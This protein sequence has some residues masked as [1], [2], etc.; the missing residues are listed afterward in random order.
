[1]TEQQAER[2]RRGQS[3][4]AKEAA[5]QVFRLFM[6]GVLSL[7]AYALTPVGQRAKQVWE[8]PGTLVR[9]DQRLEGIDEA[10]AERALHV[11]EK[12]D[13]MQRSIS[14]LQRPTEVF[15]I[16]VLNSGPIRGH[17]VELAPCDVRLKIS[18]REETVACR[19]VPG[20]TQW[21]F[22]NPR[23]DT[24]STVRRMDAATDRNIGTAW[25]LI[26]IRIFT[27][28]GLEPEALFYFTAQ[29]VACP[30][31][32]EGTEPITDKSESIP[33]RILRPAPE[34]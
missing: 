23:T 13:V 2:I 19:I 18:R 26:D 14:Q 3:W 29:Y 16:S 21:A 22:L 33:F 12:L 6:L 17:C 5:Q 25:E 32:P 4:V 31:M 11:D 28:S 20:S 1:M 10:M 30:G 15:R 7:A 24:V 9:I 34:R 27:P 8:S